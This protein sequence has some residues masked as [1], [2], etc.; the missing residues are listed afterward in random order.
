MGASAAGD[1]GEPAPGSPVV[2]LA[3]RYGAGASVVGDAAGSD[4]R[5]HLQERAARGYIE[6]ATAS[7]ARTRV[8]TT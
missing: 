4:E 5:P 6:A 2:T 7:A 3:A 8:S 1:R